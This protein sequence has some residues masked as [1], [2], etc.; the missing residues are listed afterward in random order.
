[1]GHNSVARID[2]AILPQKNGLPPPEQATGFEPRF[3][4][5]TKE[6]RHFTL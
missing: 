1:M 3:A 5:Q 6:F 4:K 2:T